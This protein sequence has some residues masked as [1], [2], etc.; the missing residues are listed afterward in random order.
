VK[1]GAARVGGVVVISAMLAGCAVGYNHVLFATKSNVGID[2]DTRPPTAEISLARREGVVAPSFEKGQTP[3]VMASFRVGVKGLLGVFANVSATFAGGD[4]A[5]TM[6][7]LY[8]DA[9]RGADSVE[10]STLCLGRE[11]SRTILGQQIKLPKPGEIRPFLFGTDTSL[12]LKVAW[13]GLTAQ[14][15]DTVRFG[16]NRKEMAWA[17]VFSK[18][19]HAGDKDE[20]GKDAKCGRTTNLFHS[21]K[22]PSFLATIDSSTAAT[23]PQDSGLQ[24]LQY[25]ATGLAASRLALRQEVRKTM[26]ARLDPVAAEKME[27]FLSFDENQRLQM[28]AVGRIQELYDKADAGKKA[29]IRARAIELKLV[30]RGTNTDQEFKDRLA[31]KVDGDDPAVTAEL[32]KLET[33]GK[34]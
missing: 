2:I 29:A 26:L 6:A 14:V 1:K 11:P 5:A 30:P 18:L 4:A 16:Y 3:P 31:W 34:Q 27:K 22:I 9:T 7:S 20:D 10:D 23:T 12:G 28:E 19:V 8:G 15:P 13:S 17:P 33:F 24:H 21:V 32:G 25:F